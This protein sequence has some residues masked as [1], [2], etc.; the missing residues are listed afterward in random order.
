MNENQEKIES[1]N[2]SQQFLDEDFQAVLTEIVAWMRSNKGFVINLT[3]GKEVSDA[4]DLVKEE[5]MMHLNNEPV[6][7]L[8]E[9]LALKDKSIIESLQGK[10]SD[11]TKL[12]ITGRTKLLIPYVSMSIS[13]CYQ[14]IFLNNIVVKTGIGYHNIYYIKRTFLG[15]SYDH[16]KIMTE[17][18]VFKIAD[19]YFKNL[20][21]NGLDNVKVPPKKQIMKKLGIK[22]ASYLDKAINK[23]F[24][25]RFGT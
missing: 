11:R 5:V 10:F 24:S 7:N 23:I 12:L 25:E 3:Q 21:K 17:S 18:D 16:S 4:I 1:K 8:M 6:C 22:S 15:I 19:D 20:F 2:I 9:R 14:V 13:L